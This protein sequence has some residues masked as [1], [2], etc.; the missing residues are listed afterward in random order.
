VQTDGIATRA[1]YGGTIRSHKSLLLDLGFLF[2]FK[3]HRATYFVPALVS[4]GRKMNR[5]FLL[6]N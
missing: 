2:G 3:L 4:T 1:D 5:T 6:Q